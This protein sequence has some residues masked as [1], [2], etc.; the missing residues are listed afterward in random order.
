[1]NSSDSLNFSKNATT[2]VVAYTI[3]W[4]QFIYSSI[5]FF[6]ACTVLIN[7]SVFLN[8]NLIDR[9]YKFLLAEALVDFAYIVIMGCSSLINC[10]SPCASRTNTLAAQIVRFCFY[11]YLTSCFAI[12]N[13]LIE[14]FLS[15]ERLFVISNNHFLQ[16]LPFNRVILCIN[17]FAL[18]YYTPVLLLKRFLLVDNSDNGSSSYFYSLVLTDIGKSAFGRAIPGVLSIIRLLLATV[19]LFGI[20]MT[21][22][23]KFKRHIKRKS[24]LKGIAAFNTQSG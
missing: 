14:I 11:D 8:K 20:N 6:G 9:T 1:M 16:T 7:I 18:V 13:I 23:I 19:C 12:N 10:G 24:K 17:A 4:P 22:F 15:L 3:V 2:V 21:T 5:C